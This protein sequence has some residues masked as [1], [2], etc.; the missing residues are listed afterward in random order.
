MVVSFIG[1]ENRSTWRKKQML[2]QHELSQRNGS[3]TIWYGRIV[4]ACPIVKPVTKERDCWIYILNTCLQLVE[5]LEIDMDQVILHHD[6]RNSEIL[7]L[8]KSAF[9]ISE[10]TFISRKYRVWGR[11]VLIFIWKMH[12]KKQCKMNSFRGW[13]LLLENPQKNCN[14]TYITLFC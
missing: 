13:C 11:S 4:V 10:H 12:L 6:H 1:G 2:V 5:T 3:E 7:F 8:K 9:E 14:I